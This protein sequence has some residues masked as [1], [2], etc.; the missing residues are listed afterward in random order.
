M[1]KFATHFCAL[2]LAVACCVGL[3]CKA[4]ASTRASFYLSV[5]TADV[6]N[7]GGGLIEVT[8]NVVANSVAK[9][10]GAS[11]ILLEESSNGGR[12]WHVAEEYEGESWMTATNR[13]TYGRGVLYQG[14]VGCL[15]RVTADVF[16]SDGSDGDERTTNT[17][18]AVE[19][20]W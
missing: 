9:E 13:S 4:F 15:Y 20:T 8:F 16:A 12:T 7:V 11:Y 2:I 14:T 6:A 5:Y 18:P 10:L 19:A 3:T 17:S 1:R